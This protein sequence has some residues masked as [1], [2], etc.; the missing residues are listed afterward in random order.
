MLNISKYWRIS[1]AMLIA[2]FCIFILTTCNYTFWHKSLLVYPL[3]WSGLPFLLSMAIML[4]TMHFAVLTACG[5][6]YVLKPVLVIILFLAAI[7]AYAMDTYG[8]VISIQAFQNLFETDRKEIHD[9]LNLKLISYL[10]FVAIIPAIAIMSLKIKY[11]SY[12]RQLLYFLIALVLT[13]GNLVIFNKNYVTF[14]RNHKQLRYY[15]NPSRPV[16]AMFKYVL[17]HFQSTQD[18]DFILLDPE[19][20]LGINTGKP[21]L[22]VLVVGESDRAANQQ[23]NGYSRDT[24][25]L[26]SARTELYSFKHFSSCGTETSVSVPCMFSV[27]AREDFNYAKGRYTENLLDILNKA[28]VQVLWR[29]NDSGCKN[30]CDR[31][32]IDDFNDSKIEPYC[33]SFECHDE[34]LLH[35]MQTNLQSSTGDKL[36]VLHKKGNHGPAYYK[37]YPEQF[38]IFTPTCKS[39]ELQDC[40][41][42]EIINAYDNIIL[43]TDYFLDKLIQQLEQN[44]EYQTA[45]IYVSDHGESL[46]EK[47]IYLHAMPYWLAPKEQTHVPFFFWASKD[48]AIDRRQLAK[49]TQQNLSHD[50]L[51]HS[52]LG[53][54]NVQ[55]KVY[56][57]KLDMFRSTNTD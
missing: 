36:I 26:L 14:L 21:R 13:V 24:N 40:T 25:P 29:D 48:F 38:E 3:N 49:I 7:S 50:N 8:Y 18:Q 20:T 11:T 16:Y 9:L 30:V 15:L 1:A 10:T 51:F 28:K 23:L 41:D 55:T 22:I 27:F 45:M 31:V 52:I 46:G 42:Q 33:N 32:A 57:P 54:F 12:K 6:Q 44:S 37:R 56:D 2:I 43:Y 19:P 39:N 34:I 4:T 47:G 53:L 35:D 17:Q 5:F